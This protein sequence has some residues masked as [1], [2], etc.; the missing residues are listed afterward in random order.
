MSLMWGASI[1]DAALDVFNFAVTNSK[2][3]IIVTCCFADKSETYLTCGGR[4]ESALNC[5]SQCSGG[6][7][8]PSG[9]CDHCS[10]IPEDVSTTKLTRSGR[11]APAAYYNHWINRCP[12]LCRAIRRN[13][14]FAICCFHPL[15]RNPAHVG[16]KCDWIKDPSGNS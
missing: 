3:A 6:K 15:C 12:R 13:P 11:P 4:T 1:A 7:L 16:N 5:S 14:R 2:E 9:D 10:S 8:C